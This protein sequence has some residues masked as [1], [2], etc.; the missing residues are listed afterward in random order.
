MTTQ[1]LP[2]T[3]ELSALRALYDEAINQINASRGHNLLTTDWYAKTADAVFKAGC[4]A[5]SDAANDTRVLRTVAA[6]AGGGKT[7]FS[8]ALIVAATR[9]AEHHPEA[10]Y[11]CAFV[12][13]QITKADEVYRD[14]NALLPGKVAIWTSDHDVDCKSP[15]KMKIEDIA[16]RFTRDELRHRPVIVVTNKFYLGRSGYKARNVFRDCRLTQRAL[17]I[18]DERPEETLTLE[19]TLS[20][21]QAVRETLV[22]D[23]PRTKGPLDALLRRMEAC[24]YAPANSLVRPGIEIDAATLSTELKWFKTEEAQLLV[25]SAVAVPGVDRLFAFARA[26]AVGRGCVVTNGSLPYFFG[27]ETQR[28]I[29]VSAGTILLDATADLDGVSN[30]VDWREAIETPQARY[31]N[32]EIIH[33]RQHTKTRLNEYLKLAANRRLYAAWMENTIRKH[34]APGEHGL[35]VCKK[36][37]IEN[38]NVPT[39]GV[40]DPRFAD[41]KNYMEGFKWDVEGRKLCVTHYGAGIGCN[42]WKEADVVLLF[43]E[44]FIPRRIAIATTQGLR[45]HRVDQGALSKMKTLHSKSQPVDAIANGHALRYTKQMALRGRARVYDEH[46]VCGKQRLVIA[47]DLKRFSVNINKLFPGAKTIKVDKESADSATL[48]AKVIEL[49]RSAQSEKITSKELSRHLR[50][51][52]RDISGKLLTE[53]FEAS[54]AAVGWQYVQQLGRAGSYFARIT[55]D[56]SAEVATDRS[57]RSLIERCDLVCRYVGTPQAANAV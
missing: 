35:I 28:V 46:G 39:W 37:L 32:L 22:Q 21:A 29:D 57:D 43:D 13:D 23:H 11:G 44:F 20:E 49:L 12:V 30:I 8:Y 31:D 4:L 15:E 18:V 55:P 10:P 42:D 41:P 7:S 19:V 51:P 9:Y 45:D 3:P 47:C 25:K 34:M 26:L 6:P 50:R 14:L 5:L 36:K 2:T 33:V 52:W 1:V 56:Q 38:E 54:V 40:N 27:Y 16:A 53:D 48:G 24:S 17:T